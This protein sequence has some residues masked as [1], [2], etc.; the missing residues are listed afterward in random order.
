MNKLAAC[1]FLMIFSLTIAPIQA[2]KVL[3]LENPAKFKRILFQPGDYI[4]FGTD[5]T[6]AKFSGLIE[7]VDDSVVVIVKTV[8]IEN[9]GDAT[10]NVFR[11]YVPIREITKVYEMDRNW[12]FFF[13]NMYSG[14]AIIGGGALILGTIIN[15][16]ILDTPPDPNSIILASSVSA[17]GLLVRYLGRNKYKIGKKWQLRAMDPMVSEEDFEESP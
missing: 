2:Q 17:S 15:S 13:R 11:D 8:K 14:T 3:S 7:S 16:I 9:E 4:R 6:Q 10:T 1:T 5:D 12:W